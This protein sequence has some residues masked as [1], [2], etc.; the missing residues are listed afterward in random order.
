MD[1]SRVY[2]LTRKHSRKWGVR[3]MRIVPQMGN[4][5]K[6]GSN[7]TVDWEIKLHEQRREPGKIINVGWYEPIC[8]FSF[9]FECSQ[10]G[11]LKLCGCAE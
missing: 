5:S 3:C 1:V 7:I 11:L 8:H 9:C 2:G 10:A 6:W 4:K